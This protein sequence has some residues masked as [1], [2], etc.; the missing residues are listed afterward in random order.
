MAISIQLRRG[1][2]IEWAIVNP[3]LAQ[4][5]LATEIDTGKFKLGDGI[6]HWNDLLYSSGP[7]G[8]KGDPGPSGPTGKD[9]VIGYDGAIG[10]KGDPGP[11]GPI[12]PVGPKYTL[13]KAT[14]CILG[15]VKIGEG[16]IVSTD[17]TVA[18]KP[19]YLPGG[20]A[21]NIR[22]L[23]VSEDIFAGAF[24]NIFSDNNEAKIRLAN[25]AFVGFS[26]DGFVIENL[27]TDDV[28]AVYIEGNN[29]AVTGAPLEEV[30]LDAVPG[31]FTNTPPSTA[32]HIVQSLGVGLCS[33][34]IA[35]N[36][37]I[38]IELAIQ[39]GSKNVL[40]LDG[41]HIREASPGDLLASA[42]YSIVTTEKTS[43]VNNRIQLT[44]PPRG[45]VVFDLMKVY[46][47]GVLIEY[48]G[49]TINEESG[50]WYAC[51][52]EIITIEGLGV[53]SYLSKD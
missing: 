10:P 45:G 28:A 52:N 7:A 8:P 27:L 29:P 48:D 46:T 20:S 43:V 32:G 12:G 9:G 11:I 39:T 2:A 31:K 49:I 25:S 21:S 53:V 5:E 33:D 38:T 22:L 15:G 35:V 42:T 30:F 6:H 51:L 40:V 47:A 36:I 13:P 3:I 17:G 41:G 18:L 34:L 1:L 44:T 26:A 50:V 14:E 24:V 37:G 19:E 23:T 16:L 4:A